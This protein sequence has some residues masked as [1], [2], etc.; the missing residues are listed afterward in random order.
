MSL[1]DINEQIEALQKQKADIELQD[2]Q[3]NFLRVL[4]S[5]TARVDDGD[6]TGAAEIAIRELTN[7][8]KKVTEKAGVRTARSWV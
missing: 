3:D 4:K 1:N 7:E 6:I 2:A 5:V 8:A